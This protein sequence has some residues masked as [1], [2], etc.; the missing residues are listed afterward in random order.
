MKQSSEGS[1]KRLFVGAASIALGVLFGAAAFAQQK[2]LV[3]AAPDASSVRPLST[4]SRSGSYVLNRNLVNNSR[5]GADAV[6]I[7]TSNVVLD[8]SGFSIGCTGSNTGNG[9]NA[10]GQTNIVIRN[11]VISG[12]G[13][14]AIITGASS[15]ISGITASGNSTTASVGPAIQAGAGSVISSNLVSGSGSG[16]GGVSCGSGTGCLVRDNVIQNNGGVG[17]TL[18]DA[19]GGYRSNVLQGNNGN[20]VGTG[21]Q[22]SGGTSL[23]QNLCNGTTC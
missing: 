21:G 10:T 7:T 19:T 3:V 22:V 17:I 15:S 9:I 11:G 18:S 8:L 4:I 2:T 12:C 1:I 16:N 13:G 23:G 5:S 20:T 14:Q 6:Q